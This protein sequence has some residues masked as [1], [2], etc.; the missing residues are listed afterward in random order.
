M[1][2]FR[3]TWLQLKPCARVKKLLYLLYRFRF[4]K[5]L[6]EHLKKMHTDPN[7]PEIIQCQLCNK[8]CASKK[9]LSAHKT[10]HKE[11]DLDYACE[12]CGK[13]GKGGKL[14]YRKHKR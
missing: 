5:T 8:I 4:E 11:K 7:Q 1:D 10:A 6:R 9:S 14:A 3:G 2:C 12:L 13:T